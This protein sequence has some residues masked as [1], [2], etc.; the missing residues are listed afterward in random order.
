MKCHLAWV[1]R[2]HNFIGANSREWLRRGIRNEEAAYR[3]Q[4]PIFLPEGRSSVL[5]HVRR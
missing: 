2:D 4:M 1:S 5:P 3:F